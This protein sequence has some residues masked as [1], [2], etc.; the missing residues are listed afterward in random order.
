MDFGKQCLSTSF[1]TG[2]S[3]MM[4]VYQDS[5]PC[6]ANKW[7]FTYQNE[8][9]QKLWPHTLLPRSCLNLLFHVHLCFCRPS[10]E[11]CF[12]TL[13]R[14]LEELQP[15]C[16]LFS[17]ARNGRF[18]KN[19]TIT[20][21]HPVLVYHKMSTILRNADLDCCRHHRTLGWYLWHLLAFVC[22]HPLRIT[23]VVLVQC[24]GVGR[25]VTASVTTRPA[26]GTTHA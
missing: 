12:H 25:H 10:L 8:N 22:K 21:K 1:K 2:T 20:T 5:S 3:W 13:D 6:S 26:L 11:K 24:S 4:R 19:Y 14:G 7:Q 9:K 15:F 16:P 17:S 18:H 23:V